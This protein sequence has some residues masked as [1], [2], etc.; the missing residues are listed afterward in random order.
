M[1]GQS[2]KFQDLRK[3]AVWLKGRSQGLADKKNVKK[4]KIIKEKRGT[5]IN[6]IVLKIMADDRRINI[7][8]IKTHNMLI[9]SFIKNNGVF[10]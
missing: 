4:K 10:S 7:S 8:F 9:S 2:E 1:D 6:L 3:H 5:E